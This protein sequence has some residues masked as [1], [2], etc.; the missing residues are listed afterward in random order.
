MTDVEI[1]SSPA[2]TVLDNQMARLQVGDQV[3]VATSSAQS[4][5]SS[6]APLVTNIDYKDTGVILAVTPHINASG[7]VMLDI[8]Q[9]VSDVVSTTTSSLNSPT[10]EQRKI[11]SS[12]AVRSGMDIVLGGLISTNRTKD[13]NGVP[14]LMDIP[15]IGNAFKSQATTTGTRT[16]LL[17]FLRPTVLGTSADIR[18]VTNEIKSRMSGVSGA[19]NR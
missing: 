4:V 17:V 11:N 15:V 5:V 14:W 13:N 12:V 9:E 2:L 10:I 3:P 18:N 19:M 6:D 8:S 7:L 16:E 1:V